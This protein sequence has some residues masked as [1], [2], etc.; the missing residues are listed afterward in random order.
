MIATHR[1][2]GGLFLGLSQLSKAMTRGEELRD[3]TIATFGSEMGQILI[4]SWFPGFIMVGESNRGPGLLNILAEQ[5]Y[6]RLRG[7]RQGLAK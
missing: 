1:A 7:L 6:K 5:I 4:L 3:I 2:A